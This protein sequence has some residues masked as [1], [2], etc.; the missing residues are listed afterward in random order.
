MHTAAE[1]SPGMRIFHPTFQNG[2]IDMI[3]TDSPDHRIAV[4]FES[5]GQGRKLLL[6]FAKF[7][8]L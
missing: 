7:K 4:R 3:D 6:K 2:V 1:L 8:I 5:D